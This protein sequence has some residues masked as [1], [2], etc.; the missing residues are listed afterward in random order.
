MPKLWARD[1]QPVTEGCT[2][3]FYR[4]YTDKTKVLSVCFRKAYQVHSSKPHKLRLSKVQSYASALCIPYALVPNYTCEE[5]SCHT[6]QKRT[7]NHTSEKVYFHK[8]R[9]AK[10]QKIHRRVFSALPSKT[11]EQTHCKEFHGHK[12]SPIAH[13][14]SITLGQN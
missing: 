4:L 8:V 11:H 13:I 9:P 2:L 14:L 10:V 3:N 6:L 12:P 1:I 5:H 7:M